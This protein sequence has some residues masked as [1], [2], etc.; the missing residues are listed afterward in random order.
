MRYFASCQDGSPALCQQRYVPDSHVHRHAL[1]RL[2]GGAYLVFST[3]TQ[4]TRLHLAR[5][6]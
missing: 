6:Y 4:D 1:R 5:G 2:L 3:Q